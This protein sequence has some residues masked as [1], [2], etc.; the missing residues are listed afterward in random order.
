V[1]YCNRG[2]VVH[3][4]QCGR[5]GTASEDPAGGHSDEHIPDEDP[6]GH[7]RL[8]ER[9]PRD[10]RGGQLSNETGSELHVLYVGEDAYSATLVYPDAADPGGVG[11]DD[12]V[13]AGQLQ[14]QFEQMSRRVLGTEAEKVREAGDGRPGAPEDGQGGSGDSRSGGGAGR[15]ASGG[16]QP[17]FG[18]SQEGL[19]VKRLRFGDPP[20]SLPRPGHAQRRRAIGGVAGGVALLRLGP[21]HRRR[22]GH[23]DNV[24]DDHGRLKSVNYRRR[25]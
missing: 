7:R 17:G 3:P 12:P 16:G 25:G 15:R 24:I 10:G 6:S 2:R 21:Q 4:Q 23:G 20:R 19:D 1:R 8:G 14:R 5:L 22:P 13:L 11:W 9:G 18:R